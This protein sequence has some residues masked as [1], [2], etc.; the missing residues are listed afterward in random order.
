MNRIASRR[1][2]AVPAAAA[3]IALAGSVAWIYAVFIGAGSPTSFSVCEQ[4]DDGS[5]EPRLECQA[6]DIRVQATDASAEFGFAV[7]TGRLNGDG[8]VDLVVGDPGRNRVYVFFGRASATAAYGLAEDVLDRGIDPEAR[9]DVILDAGGAGAGS[10]GFSL[11]VGEPVS[12]TG[13]PPDDQGAPLLVG[14]PGDP[15]TAGSPAGRAFYLPAGRLCQ[16]PADPASPVILD[17]AAVGQA[18]QSPS[19][20]TDDEFGYSVALGRLLAGSTAADD[21]VIVGARGAAGGDGRVTIFPVVGGA[22]VAD[23][24][25]VAV[26]AAAA[27]DG[28]GEVLAVGDLDQDFDETSAPFG[29]RD[30]LAAGAVGGP[31]GKVLLVRG[32]LAPGGDDDGD[33]VYR[34]DS[35]VELQAI[36]GEKAGDFFGFSVAVSARGDLSVGAIF[37][38]NEPWT[39]TCSGGSNQGDPCDGAADCPNATCVAQTGGDPRTNVPGSLRRNSGKAYVWGPGLY[40]GATPDPD[41]NSAD[42]V[43]VARRT[44]DQLGF[45]VGYGDVDGSGRPDLIVAARR[46]D[47]PGLTLNQ[48]DRGTAYVV[49]ETTPLTSPVDLAQCGNTT[50]CTGVAGVDLLLFGGDRLDGQGDEL[51]FAL[52][53]GNLNGDGSDDIVVSSATHRRVY[54]VTLEDTDDDRDVAGRN[55]RD[56]DDDGDGDS[57]AV[58]CDRLDA[59]VSSS[60][61]EVTCNGIDDNCNGMADDAPDVDG[62]G[63]DICTDAAT[64][65]DCNDADPN[66]RPGA[67]ELCDGNDNDCNGSVPSGERDADGDLYV[68][69]TGWDDTQRDQ[70][71]ILGSGDCDRLDA[72]TF[73][74]AA[75][76]ESATAC[77]RDA[78]RDGWGALSPP[79]T[80]TPGS[81]CADNNVNVFPGAAELDSATACMRDVDGDG[82]GDAAASGSVARGTDCRDA[83]ATTFPGAAER[84]DGNDNACDGSVPG[85]ELDADGD[86]F[87]ACAGWAD[88]QADDAEIRGGGDCAPSDPDGFPGAAENEAV[89]ETCL[90]DDDGDGYGALAPPPGVPAGTDCDDA[91]DVTFP[92]AALQDGPFN[93]M[94]DADGD[95]HGDDGVSLPVVRGADCDDD[96]A[97]TFA[98]APEVPD[99]AVDQDCNGFDTVSCFR[100]LDGDGVGGAAIRLAADGDCADPGESTLGTDCNDADAAVFPGRPEVPD[101]GVD[102]D[103][104]GSDAVTCVADADRDGFGNG[105]GATVLAPDGSCD[106]ADGEAAPGNTLDCDDADGATFPGAPQICDGNDNTCGGAVPANEQDQ[107]G[108]RYVACAGWSDPQ[109]DDPAI[110]GGGDCDETAS[111]TFPGAAFRDIFAAACMRDADGDGYGDASA[112]P[113]VARGT[114]CDDVSP[115]APVTFPGASPNE[116]FPGACTRD[117]DG[118]DY[119]DSSVAL[120]VA[121]GTDCD[122]VSPAAAVTFPGAAALEPVAACH[123]DADGDGY[124]DGT[125]PSGVAAGTD[126]DDDGPTAPT[127]FP[128]APELC[129]G[130]DNACAGTVPADEQDGDGDGYVACGGWSDP[131][132]DDPGIAG[133]GDCDAASPVTFPGA[134]EI[135]DPAVCMRDAD[136]DG[137]GDEAAPPGVQPGTDCDDGAAG[138]FPGAAPL[139]APADCMKDGDGDDYG[140]AAAAPPAVAGND[141]DD[142]DPDAF[143][144]APELPND[145]VD[146]DCD[147]ADSTTCFADLDG[148]GFGT[149]TTVPAPDM[150]CT[151]PGESPFATDCDDGEPA[152]FPGAAEAPG[153]A[154]DQDCNGFDG[155]AC[156]ADADRDG[157]GSTTVLVSADD[158]CL[159][160]GESSA[161]DDCDDGS[162]A[163]FPGAVDVPDDGVDQDCTGADTITCFADVDGDGFG[164]AV[165]IPAPDGT[166]D[167][168]QGESS[169][170]DDCDDTR[171]AIFPGAAETTDDGIDQDCNGA[172]T[173]TCVVDADADG[174]GTDL[175]TSVLAPDGSCD[176][177][178]GEAS[179]SD[180]CD[181]A[182]PFSF[183]GA[184]EIPGDGVDQDC[185]G[186]DSTDCFRDVDGD[187]FGGTAT[188]PAGDGDCADPGESPVSTDCDDGDAGIYPGAPE[189]VDD[190]VDDDC[191]GADTIT[192]FVDADGDGFG[193]GLTVL[194]GDGTCDPAQGES[195]SDDDCDDASA[196]RFP[197]AAEVVDDGVDQNCN[198]ADSVTCFADGDGDGFGGSTAVVAADGSCDAAQGEAPAADDCNDADPARYP[199]AP[200]V[201]GDGVDQD[202]D[203]FDSRDCFLD[204]DAD[205]FG[206]AGRVTS[207]DADCSDTGEASASSDCDDG[208][209]SAF[210]GAP[211]TPDDGVDQSCNGFDTVTCFLDNDRDGYGTVLGTTVLA[212]DGRCDPVQRESVNDGDCN[213]GN[214]LAFPG[215]AEVPDDGIDQDCNG[216]DTI[217]CIVDADAD[218]FGTTAR[219]TVLADDGACDAAQGE[220]AN[221]DDCNDADGSIHPGAPEAPLDGVDQD[222]N[223][224]DATT[225]FRDQDGDGYG[226]AVTVAPGDMD[227]TDPGESP[228]SNDCDDADDGRHPGATE[229]LDDGVDQDCSGADT[230]TCFVDADRDGVGNA[231]GTTVLA[232][233]GACEAAEGEAS[234]SGDCDE[235]DPA[236]FPGAQE[237][238]DG[239]DNVCAGSVPAGETDADGDGYVACSGWN[240]TQGDDPGVLGGGDCAAGDPLTYPGAAQNETFAAACMSDRDDDGYGDLLAPAGITR[241]T[242][243]DDGDADTFPGAA[244]FDHP[245][246][247]MKDGDRD[248]FGDLDVA[249]PVVAGTDCNDAD[250]LTR[251]GAPERCDGNDNSCDGVVPA[252]ERDLDADRYVACAGWSDTQGDNPDI[253]GSGDC[254]PQNGD[255]FPN[256]AENEAIPGICLEDA[257][258]DG[259]GDQFPPA[260]VPAGT[261]CDDGSGSTFPGAAPLDSPVACM[262]DG[263]GDDFGDAGAAL[264]VVPGTDCDDADAGRFPG[265]PEFCGDGVDGDCDGSDPSCAPLGPEISWLDSDT[266]AWSPPADSI[267]PSSVYRGDLA[268]LR[269]TGVYTQDPAV[270]PAA[271]RFCG[272]AGGALDDRFLPAVGEPVFY[273]V[274]SPTALGEAGLGFDSEGRVRRN[275][276]PCP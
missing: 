95:D 75:E 42:L 200:E 251:P 145:A 126:C 99:D 43:L 184:A 78:D 26:L 275:S 249:L 96:D 265:A 111:N 195:A 267:G 236:T 6:S 242:D 23:P 222:C 276:R 51:G 202:C 168:V 39:G 90:L 206:G 154:V 152:V 167:L 163:T 65:R 105:P 58:D 193:A 37:A 160:P 159:D 116:P 80:V 177:A 248:D 22:V 147:G 48:I 103:C 148:D 110:A 169:T 204:A 68:D 102:Q 113:P 25:T 15:G 199:E 144:G 17:A 129:D 212:A 136:D 47:G 49:L 244:P 151:D 66:S 274:T 215:G 190:G 250:P 74:G 171:V 97:A 226:T 72:L 46:E 137:Y 121:R 106:T 131:Q 79:V 192:C 112:A 5:G 263:D 264:P 185:S 268:A 188:V 233:D 18:V 269:T 253:L 237:R 109:G 94:K 41:A 93:C 53:A 67:A 223:G 12:T 201:P 271:E 247:C 157:S 1:R 85:D 217:T 87:V 138:T 35:D 55:I 115:A 219:T 134:A 130:D 252:S 57:D 165:P 88:T 170:G 123:R 3:L 205:G 180:D 211:E 4:A 173:I 256:A 261:D 50:D 189:V 156:F 272:V 84:C 218:G 162:A 2:P 259:F 224:A 10:F 186:A 19:P 122:D 36:V 232:A 158:D 14:A 13:C 77:M 81:D 258:D 203:G 241:G 227:C 127:T 234:A 62:D 183:P 8:L 60:A 207:A 161:G 27:G 150:D 142:D 166:C 240:D 44:G 119:G 76:L 216:T 100:D 120:P 114:D 38:D 213:D 179:S 70:P 71:E 235:A 92:G 225:C 220:S 270:T 149:A 54:V 128:G 175:G 59:D 174:F 257:D 40:A 9:A 172:D 187:G 245:L 231:A 101:D 125:P 61:A 230:V 191:D 86:G 221:D 20:A 273:L 196:S 229:I 140:D 246:V 197:G 83:D 214:P 178:D 194:A 73:P 208:D 104:S 266:V 243:C 132:G 16:S 133:G 28:L 260:G 11:A 164:R 69:C 146:Q 209:P 64:A 108:D 176:A 91:S 63:F 98:G 182:D 117:A 7:A 31:N 135:E 29:D 254:A 198:G 239:D 210:P 34:E 52:A 141:C 255:A 262:R 56:D 155:V 139:D 82:Y 153:D 21:D 45:A 89:P 143:P 181:D 107:D 33:G 124:G 32:P 238:C 24:G 30:D 118:D 228:F